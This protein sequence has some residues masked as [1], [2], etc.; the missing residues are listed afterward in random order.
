MSTLLFALVVIFVGLSAIVSIAGPYV[1]FC[2][3]KH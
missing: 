2:L 3:Q 1:L